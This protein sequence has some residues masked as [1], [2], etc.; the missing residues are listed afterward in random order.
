V[1]RH[2]EARLASLIIKTVADPNLVGEKTP[3]P[4]FSLWPMFDFFDKTTYS[5]KNPFVYISI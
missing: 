3:A 4:F 5:T 2:G 1:A